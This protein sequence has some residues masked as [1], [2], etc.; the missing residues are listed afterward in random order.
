MVRTAPCEDGEARRHHRHDRRNRCPL[1]HSK[2]VAERGA[3]WTVRGT[4]PPESGCSF[5]ALLRTRARPP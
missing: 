2:N 5:R 3:G 4:V 1:Q